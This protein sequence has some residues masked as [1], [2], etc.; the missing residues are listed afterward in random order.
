MPTETPITENLI[1]FILNLTDEECD[2][3][4]SNLNKFKKEQA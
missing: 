3:I 1:E 2:Y 4:I